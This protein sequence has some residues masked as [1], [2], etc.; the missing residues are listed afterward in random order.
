MTI[1]V[2]QNTI[3][4]PFSSRGC[5]TKRLRKNNVERAA[6]SAMLLPSIAL[7]K[8]SDQR[9]DYGQPLPLGEAFS[10]AVDCYWLA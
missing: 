4:H 7:H 9:S 2:E 8:S 10:P 1:D 5:R 3:V 6:T